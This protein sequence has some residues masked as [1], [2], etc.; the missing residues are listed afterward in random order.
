M[1]QLLIPL[2]LLGLLGILALILIYVIKPNYQTKHV[3]TTYVWKLSLKYRKK[4]LPTS[5]VRNIILFICQLLILAAMAFILAQPAIVHSNNT[6]EIDTV[7]IID[8]SASMYAGTNGETRFDRAVE[9]A[10]TLSEETLQ[11]GGNASVILADASPTFLV[12]RVTQKNRHLLYDGFDAIENG[13]IK[14]SYGSSDIDAALTLS[15]DVLA[16]NPSAQIY[17]YTDIQYS[18][19]P[20]NVTVVSVAE[21]GEWNAAI[22]SA[23]SELVD[24][25][26]VVTVE[27]ANYGN[28]RELNVELTVTDADAQD[29]TSGGRSVRVSQSVYCDGDA[30]K[31]VIFCD[32]G[33]ADTESVIYCDLGLSDRFYSYRSIHIS[34]DEDDSYRTDN[35]FYLYDG[36]KELVKVL[37]ASTDPNPFF[38]SALDSLKTLFADRWQL[39]VDEVPKGQAWQDYMSGY[40]LYIFEHTAP[41]VLP[42][43]GAVLLADPDRAPAGS[44]LTLQGARGDQQRLVACN[45]M[46]PHPVTQYIVPEYIAVSYYKVFGFNADFEAVLS[47]N[48][49]PLLL[50]ENKENTKVAVL[51]FSVHYSNIALQPE[52]IVLLYNIFD[53]FLPTTVNG[54]AFEVNEEIVL[55]ARGPRVTYSDTADPVEEFPAT[56]RFS[57]PGTYVLRQELYFTEKDPVNISIFVRAPRAESNLWTV[58]DALE[59]PYRE[60]YGGSAYND[61]LIY[62]AAALVA[63]LFLEWI[64]H[65]RE[66][67]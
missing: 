20:E 34:V 13:D 24:G 57:T 36:Q 55:N 39:Q 63:L 4:R 12:Q 45:S 22:L 49:D 5:K 67:R 32:G 61:L 35:N 42:V 17:L 37:Y 40:D 23:T 62:L 11:K 54:T 52:W 25:F 9:G 43:D 28:N 29:S 41:D 65:S 44:G 3:S 30:V 31:T 16:V 18:Y 14:C 33:G 6:G 26:Y 38:T 10:R 1:M 51:P 64:L 60:N 8:S 21:T 59:D 50:V 15:E 27:V 58:E 47:I 2:G 46:V 19:V 7:A 53:Y 56:L 48:A 66:G